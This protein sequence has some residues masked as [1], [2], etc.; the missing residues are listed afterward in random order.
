MI[1]F[2]NVTHKYGNNI[3][4]RNLTYTFNSNGL[5][6]ITGESGCGKTTILD[7]L[8]KL[9]KPTQGKIINN[10]NIIAYD[11]ITN[12]FLTDDTVLDNLKNILKIQNNEENYPLVEEYLDILN[13]KGCKHKKIKHLSVG[14][15]RRVG[16]IAT[17]ALDCDFYLLDEPF[18]DIDKYN[19]MRVT[20]L[21]EKKLNE[22]RS[23]IIT[24]H[25]TE[26]LN[27]YQFSNFKVNDRINIYSYESNLLVKR[28]NEKKSKKFFYNDLILSKLKIRYFMLSL[29][30]ALLS[31]SLIFVQSQENYTR[32][33]IDSNIYVL[34]NTN[35]ALLN[36]YDYTFDYI[37][38]DLN[39][40]TLNFQASSSVI[41][42]P[43]S[44]YQNQYIL[45]ENE[46]LISKIIYE[47]YQHVSFESLGIDKPDKLKGKNVTFDNESY[48]VKDVL[49]IE[50][51]VV[52]LSDEKLR[53]KTIYISSRPKTLEIIK[54]D[55]ILKEGKM[56]Q[57]NARYFEI[58]GDENCY[59]G[60]IINDLFLV[61]GI[62]NDNKFYLRYDD[63][64]LYYLQ[65]T[66]SNKIV[67]SNDKIKIES[68]LTISSI[69]YENLHDQKTLVIENE[70][71]IQK[72][73]NQSLIFALKIITIIVILIIGVL[74]YIRIRKRINIHRF[75]KTNSVII[76]A[77]LIINSIIKFIFTIIISI[78][79]FI[80]LRAALVYVVNTSYLTKSI[81]LLI[82]YNILALGLFI[83]VIDLIFMIYNLF[84]K[85]N[86]FIR[87]N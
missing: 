16:I 41:A 79:V 69:A 7:L 42:L 45:N 34:Y 15:R 84:N 86:I 5:Y 73:S 53:N 1:K 57:D 13:I 6:I 65:N 9:I 64:K 44:L 43:V 59:I 78:L 75:M 27:N 19:R 55:M 50:Y 58:I 29:M 60:D 2:N 80:I 48:I 20:S 49:D 4:L 51:N 61:T 24:S 21:I 47:N 39:Y 76:L 66:K 33:Y 74:E 32:N 10:N 35:E 54:E 81:N 82:K 37:Q 83:I 52:Y 67:Y 62:S 23:V 68:F 56:P 11:A 63:F 40:S 31:I 12:L 30:I 14:Q 22:G 77:N 46:I 17:L 72:L 85:M 26:L 28:T 87:K 18:A 8:Y 71:A 25:Q 38:G 36:Y 70:L 3:I